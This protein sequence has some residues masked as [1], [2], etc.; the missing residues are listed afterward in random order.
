MHIYRLLPPSVSALVLLAACASGQSGSGST[1]VTALSIAA[2][3]GG[4]VPVV[5]KLTAIRPE[6]DQTIEIK[7]SGLGTSA[8]YQGDSE[9]YLYFFIT[10]SDKTTWA[11]G[12]GAWENWDCTV[13]LN[14]TAWTAK[15]IT[16]A[17]F[18]GDYGDSNFTLNKGDQVYVVVWNPESQQGPAQ[19]ETVTVK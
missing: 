19:S 18:T 7:G 6:Q 3:G 17:G 15:K 14:V 1:P 2:H 11:A 13:G 5:T 16:V 9:G 8:P 4:S 10:H 12:C